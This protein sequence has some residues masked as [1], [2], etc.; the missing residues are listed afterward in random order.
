MIFEFTKIFV[1]FVH[2]TLFVR[3]CLF[4]EIQS[5]PLLFEAV[6]QLGMFELFIS[7]GNKLSKIHSELDPT[8]RNK[9]PTEQV[10][11]SEED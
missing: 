3:F 7:D 5:Q 4:R 9:E 1:P 2:I 11:D 8:R 10:S 6:D